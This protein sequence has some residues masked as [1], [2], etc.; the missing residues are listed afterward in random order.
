MS[1]ATQLVSNRIKLELAAHSY[2]WDTVQEE[3]GKCR[4]AY[5]EGTGWEAV[6][7][8]GRRQSLPYLIMDADS[9]MSSA[10]AGKIH[11]GHN[12]ERGPT[13]QTPELALLSLTSHT[14]ALDADREHSGENQ[15][16]LHA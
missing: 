6:L 11:K 9:I 13:E 3:L 4:E 16:H 8:A 5:G 1:K 2:S 12:A 15:H 14:N 10:Q 7:L